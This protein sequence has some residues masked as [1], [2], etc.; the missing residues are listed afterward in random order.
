MDQGVRE[1]LNTM[2]RHSVAWPVWQREWHDDEEHEHHREML[3]R[4]REYDGSISTTSA[5]SPDSLVSV[6]RS[7]RIVFQSRDK[8]RFEGGFE[9]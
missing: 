4:V 1:R 7:S 6:I 9:F 5:L 3:A 2:I 8:N